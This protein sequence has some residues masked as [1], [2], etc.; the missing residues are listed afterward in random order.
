[1]KTFAEFWPFYCREHSRRSTRR[2][3]LIG[4]LL[5]P[6]AAASVYAVTRSLHALWLWPLVGYGFAWV[7][8]FFVEKNRPAT[9]KYP[10]F[11]LWADY[12]MV[13]KMLTGRMDAEVERALSASESVEH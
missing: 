1:L 3:H 13:G 11:S 10:F 5:G 12:V 4:S 9:F 6:A 2:L 8:H 7:A